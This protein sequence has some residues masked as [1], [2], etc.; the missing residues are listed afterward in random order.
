M[1]TPT[2]ILTKEQLDHILTRSPSSIDNKMARAV[3]QVE[4]LYPLKFAFVRPP[5][6]M[7]LNHLRCFVRSTRLA[8]R[9]KL[10]GHIRFA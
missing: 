3:Q 7:A 6:S 2:A 9:A 4:I 10:N 5:S 8:S 1:T